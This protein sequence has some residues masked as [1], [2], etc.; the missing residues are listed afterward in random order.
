MTIT[1]GSYRCPW[2]TAFQ[3]ANGSAYI[4]YHDEE[5]GRPVYDDNKLFE[6]LILEGAQAGLSWST[7]LNKRQAYRQC[8]SEFDP[9]KVAAYD[10]A[11]ASELLAEGSGI[12]RNKAKVHSAINNAK[13]FCKLQQQHGSFNAFIWQ[14]MPDGK[15]LVNKWSDL[16]D[17]PVK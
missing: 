9:A 13:C 15:P 6:M 12:V 17:V 5:W 2:G 7:I 11:K 10:D 4:R 1:I 14:L 16:K 3:G 8:F